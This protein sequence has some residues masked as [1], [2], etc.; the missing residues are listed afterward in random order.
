MKMLVTILNDEDSECV[1]EALHNANFTVT[2]IDSTGGFLRQ[3]NSTLM[4][5]AA[6]E[7]V[8]DALD[9][10]NSQCSPSVEPI[11]RRATVFVL[12]VEHFEEI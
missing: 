9:L 4:I 11:A 5:G 8:D 2:R 7:R 1:Y 3:G 10:I 6:D 12:N